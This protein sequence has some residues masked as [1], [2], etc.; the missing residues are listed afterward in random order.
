MS[1]KPNSGKKRLELVAAL[2]AKCQSPRL[3]ITGEYENYP[4]SG[5]AAV[6]IIQTLE[7][8]DCGQRYEHVVS[9]RKLGGGE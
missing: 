7:C 8:L 6:W 2:C 3:E 5:P 9:V 1:N 4:E